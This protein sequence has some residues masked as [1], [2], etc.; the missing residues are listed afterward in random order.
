VAAVRVW[1]LAGAR[2]EAIP[3]QALVTGRMLTEGSRRRSWQA[4]AEAAEGR[5]MSL[6]SSADFE[7]LGLAVN[8]LAEDVERALDWAAELAL[9]PSFPED[10]C[11]WVA[12]RAA[13]ELQSLADHPEVRS[14]WSFLR[15]LYHPHPRSRSLLGRKST[16]ARLGPADCRNF[17][18]QALAAGVL[19]SVA[20]EI[21]PDRCRDRVNG[22]FGGVE[23]GGR[24]L[25]EPPAPQGLKTRSRRLAL[26]GVDQLYF[27][28]GR[29]TLPIDHPDLPA[30]R[31]LGIVLGAGAGLSGRIPQRVR[32]RDGLAYTVAV[33]SA[34]GVGLD[35]GRLSVF[36]ISDPAH[37][38]RLE[39]AVREE[40]ARLAAEGPSEQ[41]L[42]EACAY[43]LGREPF[44][45]ET[46][47]QWADRL[48]EA[49]L[50]GLPLDR[51]EWLVE[52]YRSVDLRRAAEVAADLLEPDSLRLT[53]GTPAGA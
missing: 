9:D 36:I 29:L 37:R 35:P 34:G 15:Q 38:R 16:L 14:S 50:Y 52:R 18:R 5:G 25:A 12:A 21:D 26:P 23:G 48:A 41:E 44:R 53:V 43:L 17:H 49:E 51:T 40:L 22:L 42:E 7:V 8:C 19:V 13:A 4:I 6:D 1:L 27:H 10:R 24:G 30:L 47:G 32:E 2:N 46:A 28:A 31:L 39:S 33:E 20:G 3:G 11:R 45:R